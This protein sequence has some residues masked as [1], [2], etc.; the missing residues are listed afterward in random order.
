MSAKPSS[1]GNA[2]GQFV[3]KVKSS[4]IVQKQNDLQELLSGP[5]GLCRE[6]IK[7]LET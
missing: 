6:K 4:D 3:D 5:L 2:F 1:V 7:I